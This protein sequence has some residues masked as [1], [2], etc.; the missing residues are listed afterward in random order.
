MVDKQKRIIKLR[1]TTLCK[2]GRDKWYI[3]Y[4]VMK[5]MFDFGIDDNLEN[6]L[7]AIDFIALM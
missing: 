1:K 2:T 6:L 4:G 3:I 5:I 7:T